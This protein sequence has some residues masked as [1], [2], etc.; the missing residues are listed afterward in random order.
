MR[1]EFAGLLRRPTGRTVL[2]NKLLRARGWAVCDVPWFEWN[3]LRN[4]A[5]RQSYLKARIALELQNLQRHRAVEPVH[6]RAYVPGKSL[7]H[8]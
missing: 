4:Q 8:R 2:R 1:Y 6:S 5:A 3:A 7:L